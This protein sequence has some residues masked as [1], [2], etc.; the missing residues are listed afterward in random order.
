MADRI[1]SYQLSETTGELSDHRVIEGV[2]TPDSIELDAAGR[3]WVASPINNALIVVDPE[4]GEW[5]TALHPPTP[6]HD[7]LIAE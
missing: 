1:L 2:P 7:R 6:E 4:T 3:R 5:S